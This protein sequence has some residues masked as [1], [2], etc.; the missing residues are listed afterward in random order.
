MRSVSMS[1]PRSGIA[2]PRTCAMRSTVRLHLRRSIS[3]TS[4]TSPAMAAAATIAG[5]INSVRPVGLPWRPLKL[6][7]ED[8]AQISRPGAG[9]GSSPGTS[10]SPRRA[11]RT[12]LH[13]NASS[14]SARPRRA[15]PANPARRAPARAARLPP[16]DDPRRLAQVG[17][18]PVRAGADERDVD[19]RAL[20][21]LP[22][23]KPMNSSASVIARSAGERLGRSRSSTPTDWPGLMPQVTVG[24]IAARVEHDFVVVRRVRVR[25]HR[26]PPRAPPA[27]T[28]R[29][30]ARTAGR[31]DTRPSSGRDSRSRRARPPRWT[32]CRWSS[33]LPST[34][35][36]SC[37]RRTRRRSRRRP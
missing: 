17:E 16:A 20:D 31:A 15:R 18:P 3:R 34:C 6:R 5:L 22:A 25:G 23:P 30:A 13:G 12:R 11:T 10:S 24:A 29:P 37:R 8:E 4:T 21:R 26:R 28:R 33:A 7:L 32:C 36:R 27:R 35:G 9:R 19:L 2:A 1:L 14:P